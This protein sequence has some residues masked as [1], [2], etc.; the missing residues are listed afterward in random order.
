MYGEWESQTLVGAET[1]RGWVAGGFGAAPE[2]RRWVSVKGG[3]MLRG[4]LMKGRMR[5]GKVMGERRGKG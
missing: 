1:K 5:G 2:V 3:S 4:V